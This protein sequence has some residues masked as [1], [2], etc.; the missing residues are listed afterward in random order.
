[1]GNAWANKDSA[2]TDPQVTRRIGTSTRPHEPTLTPGSVIRKGC[3]RH[4]TA[5][6]VDPSAVPY[7]RPLA[8]ALTGVN[9][10]IKY[11]GSKRRLIP[12]LTQIY[13]QSGAKTA[14]DLFTGTTRVAQ[15]LKGAGAQVT[16]VD[17]ARYSKVFADCYI[18]TDRDAVDHKEL[19]AAVQYLNGLDGEGGYFTD[20]FCEQ[21]RF[22]RPENGRRIDAIRTAIDE[23]FSGSPLRP[24]LLTSLIEAADRVDST[25]GV[26]MAYLKSWAPRAFNRLELRVPTLL[27]GTGTAEQALAEEF[28]E[29]PDA[30]FDFA[31]LDPP[32]N[33][34]RYFTNYHIWETLVAWDM[35]E[36]YGIACK[37]IDARDEST[38]SAFNK[39]REMPNFL[40][41]TIKATK[42]GMLVVSY[43][44]E[45]WVSLDDLVDYCNPREEVAVLAFDSKRYVGAQIGIFNPD[46]ERVGEVSHLRNL[47]YVLVAGPRTQ[48][49]AAISGIADSSQPTLL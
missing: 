10:P 7:V 47:E 17:S 37:R 33:Q 35:P 36:H 48:V 27:A 23:E 11:L 31:Y 5:V 43:N 38:K 39:K 46:G 26:Q 13:H 41:Q 44:N 3:G 21:S 40:R 8:G 32:Y 15:A 4:V 14:L 30:T 49:R 34:H 16:A 2:D 12:Q 9:M 22:F 29:K 45:S 20:V 19:E 6:C 28:V 24:I 1:M 18:A 25:T 42:A